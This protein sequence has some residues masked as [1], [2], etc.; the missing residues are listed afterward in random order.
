[1]KITLLPD[2]VKLSV[3]ILGERR[4]PSQENAIFHPKAGEHPVRNPQVTY[5]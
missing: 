4:F 3:L 1:M 5:Y 2:I